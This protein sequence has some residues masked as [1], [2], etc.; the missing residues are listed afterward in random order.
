MLAK[1]RAVK[2]HS[3]LTRSK[4]NGISWV[5]LRNYAMN[6]AQKMLNIIIMR[7][8]GSMTTATLTPAE[9]LTILPKGI[10]LRDLRVTQAR[11]ISDILVRGV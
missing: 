7:T 10:K 8:D 1:F 6:A 4:L 3:N 5:F 9:S 11:Q 2:T